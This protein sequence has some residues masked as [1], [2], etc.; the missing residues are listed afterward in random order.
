MRRGSSPPSP[1]AGD[2]RY[3]VVGIAWTSPR[4]GLSGADLGAAALQHCAQDA[5][6]ASNVA[7][8]ITDDDDSQLDMWP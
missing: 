7:G 6:A 5:A 8:S 2:K 3:G 4:R 1:P